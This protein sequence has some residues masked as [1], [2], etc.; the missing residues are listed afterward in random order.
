MVK[1]M[2][3]NNISDWGTIVNSVYN[4]YPSVTDTAPG[5]VRN[6]VAWQSTQTH[7]DTKV[8]NLIQ[9][10]IAVSSY[11]Q[12]IMHS[13]GMS[14]QEFKDHIKK[15]L[16]MKLAT[17]IIESN[18]CLFTYN[19]SSPTSVRTFKAKVRIMKP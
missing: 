10:E 5:I 14:D 2:A 4:N 8:G 19:D 13:S 3:Q 17:E 6:T 7:A 15:E 18:E 12:T 9:A 1:S 11:E 16:A